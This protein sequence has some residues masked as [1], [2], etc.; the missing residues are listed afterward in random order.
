MLERLRMRSAAQL[1][2]AGAVS[3]LVV[4]TSFLFQVLMCLGLLTI[5]YRQCLRFYDAEITASKVEG[6]KC[7]FPLVAAE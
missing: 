2:G 6:G 4:V 5:I 1:D 3:G 7:I